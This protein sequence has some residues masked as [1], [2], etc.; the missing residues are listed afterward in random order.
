[1][2]GYIGS[3]KWGPAAVLYALLLGAAPFHPLFAGEPEQPGRLMPETGESDTR[4]HSGDA[5]AVKGETLTLSRWPQGSK[6]LFV[7]GLVTAGMTAFYMWR[8]MNMTFYGKSRVTPEKEA[9]IHESPASMTVPAPSCPRQCG[10]HLSS[11]LAPAISMSCVP[12]APEKAI[13][14]NTWP[15]FREGTAMRART[16]GLPVST[17]RAASVFIKRDLRG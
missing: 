4:E 11:P 7:V 17:R 16:S 15:G 2:Q 12:Q 13:S 10:H 14:T 5:A 9:H 8:L 6:A 1:M 3:K